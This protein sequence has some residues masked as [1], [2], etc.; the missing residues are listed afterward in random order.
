MASSDVW[1]PRVAL[2]YDLSDDVM[3]FASATRGFK[4]GGWPA[5]ATV[6]NAFIPFAAE[7]VWS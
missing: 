2:Q 3:V 7:K 6:N 5:R 1:T 4:S